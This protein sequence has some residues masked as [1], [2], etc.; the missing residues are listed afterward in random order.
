MDRELNISGAI[1]D[2]WVERAN[3]AWDRP[4]V[5]LQVASKDRPGDLMIVQ[6]DASLVPDRYWLEDLGE[7]LCHGSPVAAVGRLTLGGLLSA[8]QIQFVR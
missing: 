3:S 5:I 2:S 4:R 1:V 7:N 8:T 6:A